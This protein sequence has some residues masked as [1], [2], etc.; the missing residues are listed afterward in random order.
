MSE[1][2]YFVGLLLSS[3]VSVHIIMDFF[4][5]L[6]TPLYRRKVYFV[7]EI[8][9]VL[10]LAGINELKNEWLNLS[11]VLILSGIIAI[12]LYEGKLLRKF[13]NIILLVILMSACES[14]GIL[15]LH[16]IYQISG[17]VI[18]TEKI[19][20]FF[21]MTFSQVIVVLISH[22]MIIRIFKSK[23]INNLST[24]QYL[25]TIIYAI[26][27]VI[28]I[29]SLSILMWSINTNGEII[30]VMVTIG[31]IVITNTYFLNILEYESENNR[32]VYENQLFTQQSTMQYLYYDNLE[33]Q[34]RDS[35]S[36][37]HDVKKHMRAIEELY[38]Q[39]ELNSA[40]E[41][42]ATISSIL[43]D[44]QL[45]EYSSNRVL[46]IILNDKLKVAE[47]N[48]IEFIC[49][50]D[51]V[52]LSFID[53]IDLTTIFANLLDNA[54]EAC[55]HKKGDKFIQVMVGSFHNLVVINMKN[56]MKEAK[57]GK[58]LSNEFY[59][60]N[61]KLESHIETMRNHNGIGLPNVTKVVK[62]YN[63]DFNCEQDGQIFTST[64]VLSM[65]GRD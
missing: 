14:V 20:T 38:E 6:F 43:D 62:K 30:C 27:S 4:K 58:M 41:Y 53:N 7:V 60:P 22:I 57:D 25:M 19:Q 28:N 21:E 16:F 12:K 13:I 18:T 31:G 32:L 24:R 37:I 42:A 23:N 46:N 9:Y 2:I 33:N 47:Q 36:I 3:F 40:K 56:T 8:L 59:I 1:I 11:S 63:G 15:L 61:P 39:R 5:N 49:K 55:I 54:L 52:D 10:V 26:F 51:E 64:I 44:F 50:I 34:Y 17:I 45:N 48:N 35:L 29:Y 65:Q